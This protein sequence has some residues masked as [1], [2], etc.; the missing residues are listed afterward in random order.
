MCSIVFG[1]R[2]YDGAALMPCTLPWPEMK[3][4]G[5]LI[6][7]KW[8]TYKSVSLARVASA[9]NGITQGKPW[10]GKPNQDGMGQ[11]RPAQGQGQGQ[12]PPVASCQSTQL[13]VARWPLAGG[14]GQ[15]AAPC[16]LSRCKSRES[17]QR[18]QQRDRRR[19]NT[20]A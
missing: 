15:L 1:D 16:A 9:I 14:A 2:S 20:R 6:K 19:H 4:T 12:A 8:K 7:Q 5:A 17:K 18:R 11:D 3:D 10:H 13:H